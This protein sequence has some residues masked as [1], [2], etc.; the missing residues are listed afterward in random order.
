MTDRCLHVLLALMLCTSPLAAAT[1]TVTNLDDSGAGSLRQ[2]IGDAQPGDIIEL[3][4]TGS[5][6]LASGELVVDK[7]LTIE[8]PGADLLAIDATLSETRVLSVVAGTLRLSNITIRGGRTVPPESEAATQRPGGG[9]R[10]AQ[11]ASVHATACVITDNRVHAA[12]GQS[13]YEVYGGG[14]FNAGTFVADRCTVSLNSTY[15]DGFAGSTGSTGGGL[16]NNSGAHATLR[17]CTFSGNSARGGDAGSMPGGAAG[18]AIYNR[19]TLTIET[20][21]ISGNVASGGSSGL[22]MGGDASGG[23]VANYGEL[24]IANSTIT[25]NQVIGGS[26]PVT[27]HQHG[28]GIYNYRGSVVIA[29]TVVA[30]NFRGS[31]FSPPRAADDCAGELMS[32]GYNLVGADTDCQLN[33]NDG[34][35]VGN[36]TSP[37]DA[38]LAPLAAN[39]GGT[40]THALRAGSP[41]IDA[42][43]PDSCP[44]H[45]QRGVSRPADGDG[46]GTG[47]CD[48]GAFEA[49]GRCA[50][51]CSSDGLVTV[52]ELL[53]LVSVSLGMEAAEVCPAG[54]L[55]SDGNVTVDEILS[56]VDR[57]MR[58][59]M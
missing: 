26:G 6:D 12:R 36:S 9:I 57:A 48:I 54:D 4:L 20:S 25:Q 32:S 29:G 30:G 28:G 38:S 24:S 34:D 3:L 46:D 33:S 52:D 8:G 5:I 39:G 14:I 40:A 17:D 18:G 42:G 59:C 43:H 41:A 13:F 58:S 49:N 23:G 45:D 44:A 27:G 47:E 37:I 56:A 11:G 51:D 55:N 19:G 50:G 2:A 35:L 22:S 7:D 15:W 1:L 21:T 16:Y 31:D 10:I 53:V